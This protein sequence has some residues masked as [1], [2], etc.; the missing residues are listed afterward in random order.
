[1][2]PAPDAKEAEMIGKLGR[3]CGSMCTRPAERMYPVARQGPQV[4]EEIRTF[5]LPDELL[6]LHDWLKEHR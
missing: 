4:S 6:A 5:A 1:M 2:P 3:C